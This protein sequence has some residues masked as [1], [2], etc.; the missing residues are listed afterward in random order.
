MVSRIDPAVPAAAPGAAGEDECQDVAVTVTRRA[1]L[2][3]GVAAVLG[4][5]LAGGLT[6]CQTQPRPAWSQ[7]E[8][9]GQPSAVPGGQP[10]LTNPVTGPR[11][12]YE[13]EVT[14]ILERHLSPTPANPKHAAYA[15]AVAMAVVDGKVTAHTAVG[16]ALRYGAGPTELPVEQRVPMRLDSVFD[17]ASITKVYAAILVM[18]LV[19]QGELEL[20]APVASY[21]PG[22]TG[23]GK[24][25][26]TVQMLLAH[27]SGLPV[28]PKLGGASTVQQRWDAVLATPLVGGAAPGGT[29]RYTSVGLMVAGR[30]VE[31]I[32]GQGLAEVVRSRITGPLG[33]RDTGFNP[34]T[35]MSPADRAARMVAT[36]ARSSRGLLRGVVHDDVCYR[37]GGVG[38]H[39]GIFSTASDLAV[40]GHMLLS[41]G[42]YQ[43]KRLLKASTVEMMTTNVTAGLPVADAERP[44]RPPDHGL[45]VAINQPWLMGKLA[46]A[47]AY[48][49]SGFTGTSLVICRRR[50]LVLIVL[51]N[52]AHPN[53]SWASPDPVRVEVGDLLARSV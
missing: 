31:K 35:W 45:G 50:K 14:A 33:L 22:F 6:G 29:F 10:G 46:S 39:A 2:G 16:D 9:G 8:P 4:G 25:S 30:I 12:P 49:H 23:A 26:V 41:G 53:W 13:A 18:Q 3:A 5:G 36:D 19:E 48:G 20:A 21:L 15:G 32:T 52:R 38:G 11:S 51:S 40:V 1:V 24:E 27:T 44:T 43:G 37:L 42:Q 28:G 34:Q 47:Q 7:G 17:Q